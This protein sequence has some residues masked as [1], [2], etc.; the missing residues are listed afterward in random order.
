MT[1]N[2]S[3]QRTA[4]SVIADLTAQ[5]DEAATMTTPGRLWVHDNGEIVCDRHGGAYLTA[6]IATRPQASE[7]RT[8]L[9]TWEAVSALDYPL[10]LADFRDAGLPDPTCERC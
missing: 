3:A 6:A 8:P 5:Q 1:T 7:H 9:G 2:Y 4:N 10:M